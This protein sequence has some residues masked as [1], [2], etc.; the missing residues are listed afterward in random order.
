MPSPLNG[1]RLWYAQNGNYSFIIS[2]EESQPAD[3]K[4]NGYTASWKNIQFDM[5]PLGAQPS[6]RIDGGPWLRFID[7][8]QACLRTLRQLQA[9]L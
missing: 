4:W 9:K 8:E 6:N 3:P 7:A 5:T 2:L 1:M